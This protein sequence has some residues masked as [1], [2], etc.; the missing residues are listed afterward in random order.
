MGHYDKERE[1]ALQAA[2]TWEPKF[3]V[4][5]IVDTPHFGRGTVVFIDRGNSIL[6]DHDISSPNLHDGSSLFNGRSNRCWYY[7]V[8]QLKLLKSLINRYSYI[9]LA[10]ESIRK[11]LNNLENL[12]D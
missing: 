10:I 1:D 8:Y 4:G 3:R 5:D 12:L 9:K 6:V 11:E 7:S 2:T